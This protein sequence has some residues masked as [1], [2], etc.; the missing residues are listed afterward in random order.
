MSNAEANT[1]SYLLVPSMIRKSFCIKY[2]LNGQG[3]STLSLCLYACYGTA[4]H[5]IL[6][7]IMVKY[8]YIVAIALY[9]VSTDYLLMLHLLLLLYCCGSKMKW[10]LQ[11]FIYAV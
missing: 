2:I 9:L 4:M 3:I 8:I 6:F 5:D 11:Y 7:Y 10:E 1:K